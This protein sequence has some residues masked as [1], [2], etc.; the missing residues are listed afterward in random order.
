MIASHE[1]SAWPSAIIETNLE[2]ERI[3][4]YTES[5]ARLLPLK[6]R[7]I[8]MDKP[9]SALDTGATNAVEEL[10]A[11]LRNDYTIIIVTHNIAKAR[12]VSD[13]SIFILLGEMIEHAR[14]SPPPK[15]SKTSDYIEGH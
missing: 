7:V 12:R 11:G 3:G 6:P 2:M 9:C 15:K 1:L 5:I 10:I 13:E 8:L 14:T 4:D